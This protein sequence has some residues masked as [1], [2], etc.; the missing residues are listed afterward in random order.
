MFGRGAG[1]RVRQSAGFG[2]LRQTK[3]EGETLELLEVVVVDVLHGV[4]KGEVRLELARLDF[5]DLGE[6]RGFVF[7]I[8]VFRMA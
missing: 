2:K 5:G 8:F 6:R 1:R 4:A 7:L 3:V